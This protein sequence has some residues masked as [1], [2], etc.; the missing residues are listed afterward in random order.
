[1]KEIHG[2][3]VETSLGNVDECFQYFKEL[4][5]CHA[6]HRPPFSVAVFTQQQLPHISDYVLNTY[7]R[8]FK[9]Y[10]CVFTPQVCLDLTISYEE[11]SEGLDQEENGNVTLT[12]HID[13][14]L[15]QEV[16]DH[17]EGG[18]E[19]RT[20]S[21]EG[22]TEGGAEIRTR[23]GRR[24]ETRNPS[25][26]GRTEGKSET[27]N[28]SPRGRK[29]TEGKSETRNPSP[30]GRTEGRSETRNPSP[31]GRPEGRSETRTRSGGRPK[32]RSE[33]RTRSP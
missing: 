32:G 10:K 6:V 21:P 4:L 8:H 7:F 11:E 22:R 16:Q 9:L 26:G 12:E 29:G 13:Q 2:S 28:P 3:C 31:G 30:G 15:S 18:A 23:S 1:M 25:P 5:L 33:T 27:R 24:S 20:R 17:V 19:T 14:P